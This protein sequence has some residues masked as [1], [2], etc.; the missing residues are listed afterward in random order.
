V[1]A[2]FVEVTDTEPDLVW[3]DLRLVRQLPSEAEL[4]NAEVRSRYASVRLDAYHARLLN[5]NNE[6]NL[7]HG[8]ASTT[9]WGYV[10]GKDGQFNSERAIAKTKMLIKGRA[11]VPGQDR[12]LRSVHVVFVKSIRLSIGTFH[13]VSADY[14]SLYLNEFTFRHNFRSEPDQF[15]QLIRS[16]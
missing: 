8:L 1:P 3:G 11:R 16:A 7:L 5:G 2:C 9:F 12:C 10:S 6:K 13:Q 4:K 15:R 14:L